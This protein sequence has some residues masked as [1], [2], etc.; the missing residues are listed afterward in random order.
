LKVHSIVGEYAQAIQA[1]PEI[2]HPALYLFIGSSIGNF[3][4]QEAIDLLSKLAQKMQREDFL[5]FGVDRVKEKAVLENAYDDSEGI[6][7]KFNL[8]VLKVM[9]AKLGANF[10]VEKFSHQASYN[11]EKEQI[12]MYL[13]S[14]E[15]QKIEFKSLARV[16]QLQEGEKILT[17]ISRKYTKSSLQY[18][19]AESGLAEH[20]HFEARKNQYS[21][22]LAK[23]A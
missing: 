10:A 4:Q 12:E 22:V 9:N 15:A 11:E 7:A 6:T 1:I 14:Q 3:T 5:L 21:L 18:L 17:E 23:I 2:E 13:V 20:T 19:L 8:N 16:L